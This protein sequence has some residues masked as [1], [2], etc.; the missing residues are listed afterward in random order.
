[1]KGFATIDYIVLALYLLTVVLVGA[2]FYRRKTTSREYFLG[3]KRMAWLPVGISIVAADTSA[4]TLMGTPAWGYQHSMELAWLNIGYALAAPIVIFLFIPFYSRLDLFTAYE[5]LERRFSLAIRLVTSLLFQ[6]LRVTHVAIAIYAPSIALT[7]VTGMSLWESIVLIGFL[8]TAYTSFGG[9]RAVIWTDVI[10]F[11]TVVTGLAVVFV[12]ALGSIPGGIPGAIAAAEAAGKLR[13]LDLSFDPRVETSV[14]ACLLGGIGD[15]SMPDIRKSLHQS[16]G[17]TGLRVSRVCLGTMTFGNP[18]CEPDCQ[19]LV[20]EA[21]ERGVNFFDTSNAYEGYDRS[22]GSPGGLGEELLGRSLEGRRHQAVICTKFANPVG[23]GPLDA[24]LSARHLEAELDKSLKRLRTDYI[25]IVLAHR[26]DM[27][28]TVDE[29]SRVF[30]RWVRAGKVLSVGTSNWPVWRMAQLA[31]QNRATGRLP[32]AVSSPKYNLL[33]R[34]IELE[35]IPCALENGIALVTYQPFQGGILAGRYRRGQQ[36]DPQSRG[37]EKPGWMPAIA[38]SLFERLEALEALA[39]EAGM[40]LVPYVT[41]W[42][43]SRPA[44]AAVVVGCRR[45]EQL[46]DVLQGAVQQFPQE[47]EVKLDALF[48]PPVPLSGESVLDF[49]NGAWKLLDSE[50]CSR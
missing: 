1:V 23:H 43:L 20:S 35:H 33:N 17:R 45:P 24:G 38:D 25:D 6:L 14:W 21:L 39:A 34:G 50:L 19:Y 16:L 30:E 10:Q 36:P 22:F 13:F 44:V 11:S 3:G 47:H 15:R 2:S 5:Y 41:A 9:M 4:I 12:L 49:Q 28:C 26:W 7:I 27:A 8:T 42:V 46:R 31:E 32:L 29:V 40:G 37:A 18:I 48:P